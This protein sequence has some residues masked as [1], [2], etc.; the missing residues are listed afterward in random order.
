MQIAAFNGTVPANYETYLGPLLFEPYAL[1]LAARLQRDRLQEVL[2]L[3][4]GTGRVTRHLLPLL[5][6]EGRLLASDLNADMLAVAASLLEES[7]L[8][9]LVIDAQELPFEAGRFTH[10]ICQFGWMF[11]PDKAKAF[12]EAY[13]VLLPGGKLV[14][15]VWDDLAFNPRSALVRDILQ[16]LM[17]AE[18]PDFG[19]GPYSFFDKEEISYLVLEAGFTA[20][21][22]EVV[23]KSARFR[24]ADEIVTGF[25]DGS[26][27]SYFLQR[28]PASFREVV[29]DR[30]RTALDEQFAQYG[31]TIPMQAI[32]VEA[33]K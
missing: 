29:K 12:D 11:F 8:R 18:A 7:R 28:Q 16:E 30:L 17:G 6:P 15:N 27:L 23:T 25:V 1:D 33:I 26:P 13:R 5:P 14:F 24:D 19:G 21:N 32:V 10:V 31:W 2:E 9:F 3:A 22:L 20:V 4:C